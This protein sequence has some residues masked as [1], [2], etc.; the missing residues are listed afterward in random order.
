MSLKKLRVQLGNW[1]SGSA[2][3]DYDG[4]GLLDLFVAGYVHF[5]RDNLPIGGSKPLND[6]FCQYRGVSVNCGPRG[7]PGEPD[8]LF[9]NN[10][11]GTFT[12]VTVKARVED[13]GRSYGF[14]PH[15]LVTRYKRQMARPDL[16]VVNDSS[17]NYL[18]INKGDGTFEDQG[19]VSGLALNEDGREI[20]SMGIAAGDYENNGRIDFFI[21]DFGDDYKVLY[22]PTTE[23]PALPTSATRRG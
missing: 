14:T 19:Y 8:H 21:T 17:P 13:K 9:H 10:G 1:S 15:I 3:G 22:Q 23:T 6:A 5:D 20:A 12:D 7:L 2:W 16:V 11:D 4:D 18:Y